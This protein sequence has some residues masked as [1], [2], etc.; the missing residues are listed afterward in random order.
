MGTSV[1]RSLQ[2]ASGIREHRVHLSTRGFRVRLYVGGRSDA[3]RLF[4]SNPQGITS[5]N[6][7]PQW[8]GLAVAVAISG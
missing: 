2:L 3:E 5:A 1:S 6:P 4:R 7:V 8:S